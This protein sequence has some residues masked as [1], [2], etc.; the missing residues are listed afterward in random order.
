MRARFL[1]TGCNTQSG[2]VAPLSF[3]ITSAAPYVEENTITWPASSGATSYTIKRGTTTEVYG[4]TLSTD[5]VSPY[6]DTSLTS[7]TKY[8]YRVY[9][10]NAAGTTTS[11]NE[12]S[13]R[14]P[15]YSS[16]F[17]DG[18]ADYISAPTNDGINPNYNTPFWLS[19]WIKT[20]QNSGTPTIISTLDATVVGL[21]VFMEN[22]GTIRAGLWHTAVRS[23]VRIPAVVND[24]NWHLVCISNAGTGVASGWSAW[25]DATPQILVTIADTLLSNTTTTTAD[26]TIGMDLLGVGGTPEDFFLGYLN[27]VAAKMNATLSS[28][29][30]TTIY[31]SGVPIDLT[32]L[33]P[34]VYLYLFGASDTIASNGLIDRGSAGMNF[35][36]VSMSAASVINNIRLGIGTCFYFDGATRLTGGIQ[37]VLNYPKAQKVICAVWAYI[38]T[39]DLHKGSIFCHEDVNGPAYKGW[40]YYIGATGKLSTYLANSFATADFLG[41]DTN[42]AVPTNGWVLLVWS[43][44]GSG[45]GAGQKFWICPAGTFVTERAKTVN[46]DT[47]TGDITAALTYYMGDANLDVG[48]DFFKGKQYRAVISLGETCTD[49]WIQAYLIN[50]GYPRNTALVPGVA[51]R[52]FGGSNDTVSLVED[53]QGAVDL[54]VEA[55]TG[56]ILANSPLWFP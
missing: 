28:G 40:D 19:F 53:E 48:N 27:Q 34:S 35:T 20:S 30:V 21:Y 8:F 3:S 2:L 4:T 23:E 44:D 37:S 12:V 46:Q 42:V 16:L 50:K 47:L 45:T 10:V 31:N 33:S 7:G 5:A 51:H 36:P 18:V 6:V 49:A 24:G 15:I 52:W 26:C 1:G 39:A 29:D 41:V 43:N 32:Y 56:Q 14:P 11:S 38:A 55:G 22:A 54:T 9:A 25:V 13:G 17:F